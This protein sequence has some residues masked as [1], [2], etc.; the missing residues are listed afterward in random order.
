MRYY[1]IA[2]RQVLDTYTWASQTSLTPGDRVEV[3][4][5]NRTKIGIITAEVEAPDFKT[6]EVLK[7]LETNFLAAEYLAL[8]THLSQKHFTSLSKVLTLMVPEAFWLKVE[9]VKHQIQ[10]ALDKDLTVDFLKHPTQK[11]YF[12]FL[13]AQEN[14]VWEDEIPTAFKNTH[15]TFVK[16]TFLTEAQKT[17]KTEHSL[18]LAPA[19]ESQNFD[20]TPAQ[21]AVL[22]KIVSSN[23]GKLLWGVTGSG[24]T[25]V[26]K[27]FFKT[28]QA[29]NKSA[30][31]L[32]LLPEI[33]LTPQLITAFHNM[34]SG[35]VAVWH[36]NLTANEKVQVW[37]RVQS[38][39]IKI[40][41]GTRSA[42]LVPMPKLAAIVVDEEHEWT[43]KNEFNPRFWTHEVVEFLAAK[44]HIP[45]VYGSATPKL[46][47]Y[48]LVQT[49]AL[50]L[51]ELPDRV[52]KTALPN[53]EIVDLKQEAKRGNFAPISKKLEQ[54]IASAL[55][56]KKQ[57]VLF[58]NKRGFA[59]SAMC[60]FC[61]DAFGCDHCDMSLKLHRSGNR[62]LLICHVCGAMKNFPKCCPTC[63]KAEFN[64][65]G[66]GTQQ[67]EQQLKELFPKTK[68]FRADK[69]SITG[70]YDFENLLRDFKNTPQSILLG[71]QMIAKGLDFA[72]VA[73]VG[74]V[75]A[76]V[77]LHLPDHHAEE[78]VYQLLEQVSGRAGRRHTQG[79]ILV[80]T[81]QDDLPLFTFLR[82]HDTK[83]FMQ[84]KYNEH[85]KLKLPPLSC[86]AKIIVVDHSKATAFAHCK[87]LHTNLV[88]TLKEQNL[89]AKIEATWAPAFFPK[90]HAKYWFYVF[91]KSEDEA[92]LA[93]FMQNYDWPKG[94]K[95]DVSP[96]SLI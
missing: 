82:A 37:A 41:I 75:L 65:R 27:Q 89:E 13:Q 36:S 44:K 78:R 24:K 11:K 57:V 12:E 74:I 3:L 63:K 70:R 43:F 96:V 47:S 60:R 51:V 59:G 40:L 83:G 34:F 7:V 16:K 18:N 48:H 28:L 17:I 66:W 9:P 76:D 80:Q 91:L 58:L 90:L 55:A 50:D 84:Q 77:G 86:I 4:F 67:L 20:L 38:G 45:F 62:S 88:A 6:A 23:K 26:Y 87:T 10:W 19:E 46:R 29:K 15:K 35:Q 53:I 56:D 14:L 71:T 31:F 49:G 2:L 73:L 1:Q 25:E 69:D 5:R 61:G 72:D 39:A 8:A 68:L 32:F 79:Q 21:A 93:N 52:H 85:E 33:A 92:L 95:I 81:Y 64:F 42:V 30:Q 54:A 94:V 22:E